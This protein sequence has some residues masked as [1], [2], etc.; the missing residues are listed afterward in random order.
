M[1][2]KVYSTAPLPFM[3]QKRRFLKQFKSELKRDLKS[4]VYVDLFG[5][6]GLLSHTVKRMYPEVR[7]I[8][9]DYD[10]Y[11]QRINSI[12]LTNEI[13]A[14]L[15]RILIKLPDGSRI[16]SPERENVLELLRG[17]D[18]KGYVDYLTI[19]SS[20]LFS[21][22]YALSLE[23]LSKQTLYNNIKKEGYN[24]DGYLD[25][26]EVVSMDYKAL[27]DAFKD[28]EGVVFLVDPPYLSTEIGTYKNYWK[29]A[30]YLDVLTILDSV[31]YFYF[32]SNKS[33][34][35]ELCNWI[36]LHPT[37]K[38]PFTN[39]VSCTYNAMPS[40]NTTYT[41]MMLVNL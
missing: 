1:T 9:N 27:F 39:A 24:A 16:D 14:N 19:G 10:N 38:N 15:R 3:G 36:D 5:G 37:F 11:S 6:S 2:E 23:Q 12:N 13:I 7:V 32:T 25:G 18:E 40:Y 34:I 21:M 28:T 31:K 4:E 35:V 41:D 8:Y 20:L 33:N 22:N 26:L 17:Y 29:L 30:D